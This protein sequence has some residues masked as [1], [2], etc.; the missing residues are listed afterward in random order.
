MNDIGTETLETLTPTPEE[1]RNRIARF[2]DLKPTKRNYDRDNVGVP[3]EVYAQLAADKVL[4]IM[5]PRGNKRSSAVPAVYGEPGVE[6]AILDN[7]PGHGP[8][9]H[10]HMKSVECFLC[11]TG[12]YRVAWGSGAPYHVDLEPYDFIAVPPRV[13]REV[14]NIAESNALILSIVQGDIKDVFNDVLY[15]PKLGEKVRAQYGD[16]VY[17][18]FQNIGI[19]FGSVWRREA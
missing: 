9:M 11:L 15:D 7:P 8:R 6:I 16:T 2:D 4:K 13:F 10:A 5:S 18:N 17:R 3:G 19:T 12:K 1:M 14:T